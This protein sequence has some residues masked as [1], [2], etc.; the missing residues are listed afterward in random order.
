[1][2]GVFDSGS[3]G[4]SILSA[5]KRALP[6]RRFV[7]LGDHAFQPY[8]PRPAEE[9]LERTRIGAD[10]L[11]AQGCDV[12]VLA[13]NTASVL[14]L[15]SL[16]EGWLA[17]RHPHRRMLGIFVPVVETLT[18]RAWRRDDDIVDHAPSFELGVFATLGTIRAGHFRREIERLLPNVRVHEQPCP[19]LAEAIEREA[20]PAEIDAA[21]RAHVADLA[22]RAGRL[23][24]RIVLG[25][26]HYPLV[27]DAFMRALP[28]RT[29]ILDQGEIVAQSLA[30]YLQRRAGFAASASPPGER[31]EAYF[32]T[33]DPASVARVVAGLQASGLA[34]LAAAGEAGQ[35]SRVA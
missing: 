33:G 16:Q 28:P 32:T 30:G 13:C 4:L 20:T 21:I 29:Q 27:R 17:Q 6:E 18:G 31:S 22:A 1:M 35:W 23:P 10:M 8:G 11:F 7:Y 14:A 24:S 34:C 26:T 9:V 5:L 3:G 25:C 19:G 2:I 12:V 15:R